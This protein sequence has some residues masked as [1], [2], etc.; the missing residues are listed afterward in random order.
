MRMSANDLA[1]MK[2]EASFAGGDTL[3]AGATKAVQ[4]GYTPGSQGY[5]AFLGGFSS[6][7]KRHLS[8]EAK[9]GSTAL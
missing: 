7:A 9:N 8:T 4:Q 5:S 2:G 6:M 1:W 3:E